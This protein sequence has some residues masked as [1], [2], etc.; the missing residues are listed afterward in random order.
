MTTAAAGDQKSPTTGGIRPILLGIV[1]DSATGKTTLTNGIVKIFGADRVTPLCTDDYHRYDREERKKRDI[2]PLHPDCNYIDI[3][4]QHLDHLVH[5]NPI[6]KPVYGHEHGTL[7]APELIEPRDIVVVEGLLGYHTKL[8]RDCFDVTVYLDPPEELRRRWKIQR[9]TS[10]RNY[11][12]EQVLADLDRREPDSEAFIRP[13]REWADIVVQFCPENDSFD[14]FDSAKLNVRL[15]L[16][17]TLAHPYLKELDERTQ[18]DG[19][20]PIQL[21]LERD[22][23]RPV[24]ALTVSGQLPTEASAEVERLIWDGMGL[25]DAELDRNAIGVFQE[26]D[27]VRRSESLA[28]TQLMLVAQLVSARTDAAP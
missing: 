26:G 11:T 10:K 19:L 15:V 2:T 12:P 8:M 17:P 1:G 13:Q 21:S 18:I 6:L 25:E 20:R 14:D 9:D 3:M 27:E 24:D 23:D 7:D 28:L 16:R 22:S 5:G 4:E